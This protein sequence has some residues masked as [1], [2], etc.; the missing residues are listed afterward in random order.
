[1]GGEGG[2]GEGGREGE[3]GGGVSW[4]DEGDKDVSRLPINRAMCIASSLPS[5]LRPGLRL[6]SRPLLLPPL[7]V[8]NHDFAREDKAP[9]HVPPWARAEVRKL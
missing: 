4:E 2:Y 5:V 8:E 7:K 6:T 9:Q 1:M 3:R